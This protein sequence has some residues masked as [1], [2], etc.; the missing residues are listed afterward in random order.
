MR[1]KFETFMRTKA[2]SMHWW[3]NKATSIILIPIILYLLID[4]SIY[5]GS[6]SEPTLILFLNR[7]FNNDPIL[8]FTTNVVLLWHIRAG[9]EVVIEDYIHGE[10][11][12]IMSILL[13]RVLT[14]QVMKYLYLCCIIF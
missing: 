8:I 2:G 14:I 10:K 7:L 12:K 9:M 11:V 13:T 3:G 6:Q 4:L 5:M 1:E